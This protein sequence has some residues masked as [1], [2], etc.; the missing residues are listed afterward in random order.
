MEEL[1][2]GAAKSVLRLVSWVVRFVIWLIWELFFEVLAWYVGWGVI[3]V[4]T[5]GTYPRVSINDHDQAS[6]LSQFLVSST[7]LVCLIGL[8]TLLARLTGS[9]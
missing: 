2:D 7:G 4:L 3:R 6:A 5:L 9:G 8:A 1:A